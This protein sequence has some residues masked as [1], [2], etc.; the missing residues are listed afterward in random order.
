MYNKL[1]GKIV[2]NRTSSYHRPKA[3]SMRTYD[4]GR[5]K[6]VLREEWKI[7]TL[8]SLFLAGMIIGAVAA[9]HTDNTINSRLVTMV[10]D[11]A[12]LRNTQSIFE[13]FSNSLTVNLIFLIVVFASG[14]CVVGIPVISLI[15]LIKGISLGMVSGYLYNAY[16]LN[17]AGYCMVILFPGA[18]IAT[19]TLLLGSNE[20]FVMSYELLNMINGKSNYQHENILKI[21]SKRYAI[22]LILTI[23][24]SLIDTLM[25]V[26]FASKF[27]L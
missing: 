14:L 2:R 5:I 12:M 18:V 4:F 16:S 20:S 1:G 13:T 6:M 23:I 21:Y 8:I 15:P 17:G 11:F 7:V 10:S 19:A 25:T 9:R 3:R 27:S 22:L 24:A 26:F